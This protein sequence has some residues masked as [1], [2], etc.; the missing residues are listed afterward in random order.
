MKVWVVSETKDGQ[1][2]RVSRELAAHA[3]TLGDVTVVRVTAVLMFVAV[4]VT[5]GSTASP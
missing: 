4:T 3:P 5:P 1:P 2:R